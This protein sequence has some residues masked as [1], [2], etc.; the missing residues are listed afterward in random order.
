V[1]STQVNLPKDIQLTLIPAQEAVG[2][3]TAIEVQF[4]AKTQKLYLKNN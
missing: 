4:R 1:P 3:K 2:R